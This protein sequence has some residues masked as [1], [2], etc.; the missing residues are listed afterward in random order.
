MKKEWILLVAVVGVTL[1]L[2]IGLVRW[3][4]PQLLGIP[5]DLQAVQVSKKVPPFYENIF[6]KEDYSSV[7]FLLKDPYTNV[8]NKP[9]YFDAST[10]GPHDILG[11]RNRGVPNVADVVV[12]GDSQTYGNNVYLSDNWPNQ[13]ATQLARKKTVIYSMATGGWGAVQYLEMFRHA[14]V[15]QPRV[16]VVAFYSGN[17]P[18]ESLTMAYSQKRWE[19]L[20]DDTDVDLDQHPPN[21]GFPPPASETW[22]VRFP[23]GLVTT[24]SPSLRLI[25]NDTDYQTVAAGY[26]VMFKAA[27]LMVSIASQ[28]NIKL[29]FTIIPTKELVYAQRIHRDHVKPSVAYEKL[30]TREKINIER[31]AVRLRKLSGVEY[32]DVVAPLQ[33]A[34]MKKFPLYPSNMNG[35]PVK[36]GYRVIAEAIYPTV[37][38]LLPKPIQ[39]V[40]AIRH[41]RDG[42]QPMFVDK[43]GVWIFA[44]QEVFS[45]NGWH[46]NNIPIVTLR[47]LA[48]LPMAGT[49]GSID[50]KRFGPRAVR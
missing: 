47:D 33:S 4:A 17:D 18:H 39:G 25:S 20:R 7:G 34:A 45:G 46:L 35:H 44:S 19:S 14:T 24:F 13:L 42:L 32:V 8:R 26:E 5:L 49:I 28:G 27:G 6:R 37:E 9:L 50:R 48:H 43:N 41:G 12:I 31:L 38:R 40:M 22:E 1:T 10:L 3:F 21:V 16:V 11:F 29:V 2:T 36:T 15:F 30:V 23:D